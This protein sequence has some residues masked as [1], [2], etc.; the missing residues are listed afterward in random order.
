VTPDQL[1]LIDLT[2]DV[3]LSIDKRLADR[4]Y[5]RLFE[6]APDTRRLFVHDL[7]EQKVKLLN[8]LVSLVGAVRNPELFS[9]ILTHLGRRHVGYGVVPAHYA[10][11]RTALLTS[12]AEVLGPRFTEPVSKAWTAL[13]DAVER[14]M[15]RGAG[16]S[17]APDADAQRA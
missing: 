15:L 16:A 12:L 2:S 17:S 10:A 9:S 4:F 11:T 1:E 8:M 14:E 3:I 13:Y 7:E 6:I 5:E